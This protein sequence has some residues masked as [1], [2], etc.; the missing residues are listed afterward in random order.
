MMGRPAVHGAELI[1]LLGRSRMGLALSRPNDAFLYSSDRMAQLMGNGVLT[2]VDARTG[3]GKLFTDDELV[4]YADSN[5][6]IAR[7]RHFKAHDDERRA[8]A[9][10]GWKKAHAS[11]SGTLVA[12][13]IIE[14]TF[15]LP[16]SET[17][18]WPTK[19]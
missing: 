19:A 4:C 13:W 10:R 1:S 9:Q 18:V 6:L 2:F 15:R 5:D 17:Y 8:V 11:F 7:L 3:F 14:T 12:K 16:Y